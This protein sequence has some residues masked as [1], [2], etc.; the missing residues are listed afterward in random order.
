MDA[1][2]IKRTLFLA[3]QR[4][5]ISQSVKSLLYVKF[6]ALDGPSVRETGQRLADG[7]DLL[8][9]FLKLSTMFKVCGGRQRESIPDPDHKGK[10]DQRH[11]PLGLWKE[12]ERWDHQYNCVRAA[13]LFLF[14]FCDKHLEIWAKICKE[15]VINCGPHVVKHMFWM[16]YEH[17]TN[18]AQNTDRTRNILTS[19]SELSLVRIS[20]C[21]VV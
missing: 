11:D 6:L 3:S 10:Q 13:T 16:L 19:V 4:T 8:L 15:I 17:W 5:Q 20:E 12:K 18:S 2:V 21:N 7:P 9:P 14:V 1:P